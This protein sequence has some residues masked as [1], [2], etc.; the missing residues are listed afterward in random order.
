MLTPAARS[1]AKAGV[2]LPA[3]VKGIG[4]PFVAAVAV[5][6]GSMMNF[7]NHQDYPLATPEA[8]IAFVA[9]AAGAA[10]FALLYV[11][12]GRIGRII[13]DI[14][15]VY[16]ALDL[17]FDGLWVP[18]TAVVLAGALN[19]FALPAIGIVF[20]V[21]FATEIASAALPGSPSSP[22]SHA[23]SEAGATD[24]PVLLHVI[25]DEHIGMAGLRDTDE[26]RK[27]GAHLKD[28]YAGRGFRLYG[29][30]YSEYL[31]TANA[32]PHILNFG[33]QQSWDKDQRRE[34][35]RLN[36]NSYFDHLKHMGYAI[37]VYQTNFV[38]YCGNPAVVACHETGAADMEPVL[39]SS[40][41]TLDRAKLL[42]A[43]FSQL[44]D[45]GLVVSTGI[46]IGAMTIASAGL[47]VTPPH[48]AMRLNT[49]TL[50]GRATLEQLENALRHAR[51]GQ[52]YFAH[53]LLPHY[54]YASREDCT[55]KS[56]GDW[57]TRHS[58]DH[59]IHQ[60]N[61]AYFEQVRCVTNRVGDLLD[62][63]AA[64]PA[65]ARSIVLIHGD[66]GSRITRHDPMVENIKRFDAEDIRAGYS[67]L[68]AIRAAGIAPG[69]D[70][71]PRSVASLLQQLA[72]SGF[73]NAA[74][75]GSS[76]AHAITLE[77]SD[78]RPVQRYPL[79]EAWA[80]E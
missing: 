26:A 80:E 45:I 35:V 52:A 13:L 38:D 64:S 59:S 48:I 29:G 60:R 63:L 62:A 42:L 28:F 53:V 5:L 31:H 15:L 61:E 17:N 6:M 55:I 68:F 27:M 3:W 18:V 24:A 9:L 19:R 72:V 77:D 8:G 76:A 50:G 16:A 2:S 36:S 11:A 44:S 54:P 49:S 4:L 12:A 79:P 46:D 37:S 65:G 33:E 66:H 32:V 20:G 40:L 7:L 23:V 41:D 34:G 73:N 74:D 75:S 67:T 25:L 70:N 39:H 51:P 71:Q 1:D 47:D 22:A 58:P 30:A 43:S 56:T 69:Y 10:L 57:L 78:T 14:L 21:V